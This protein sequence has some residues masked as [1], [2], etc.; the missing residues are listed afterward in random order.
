MYS[1]E[2]SVALPFNKNLLKGTTLSKMHVVAST[3]LLRKCSKQCWILRLR[4]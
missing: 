2:I 1:I 3:V 4:F